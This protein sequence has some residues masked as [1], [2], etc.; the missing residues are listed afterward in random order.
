MQ[1][2]S[3]G[4]LLLLLPP[5]PLWAPPWP[6]PPPPPPS[7]KSLAKSSNDTVADPRLAGCCWDGCGAQ[8][9]M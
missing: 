9:V 3:G 7:P 6:P 2:Q 4:L 1:H 5:L 8:P